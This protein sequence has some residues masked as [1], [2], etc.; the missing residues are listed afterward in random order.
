MNKYYFYKI[1]HPKYDSIQISQKRSISLIFDYYM[2]LILY[3]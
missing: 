3:K 2:N 1:H